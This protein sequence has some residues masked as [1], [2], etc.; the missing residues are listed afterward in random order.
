[1][2]IMRKAQMCAIYAISIAYICIHLFEVTLF[3]YGKSKFWQAPYA[4]AANVSVS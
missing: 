4:K 1:M 3:L 2:T